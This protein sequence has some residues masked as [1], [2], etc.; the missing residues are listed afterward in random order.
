M[1]DPIYLAYRLNVGAN[2]ATFAL[3]TLYTRK[4][5]EGFERRIAS[6]L[7]RDKVHQLLERLDVGA[8]VIE[9]WRDFYR[10]LGREAPWGAFTE[11]SG[12]ELVPHWLAQSVEYQCLRLSL[13][14]VAFQDRTCAL[15]PQTLDGLSLEGVSPDPT[16]MPYVSQFKSNLMVTTQPLF[17]QI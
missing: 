9:N 11:K 1:E 13:D 6:L 7:Q 17:S 4:D 12:N 2:S 16:A 8:I 15:N 10:W 14:A 3:H 5:D